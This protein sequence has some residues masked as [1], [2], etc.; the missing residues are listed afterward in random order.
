[1]NRLARKNYQCTNNQSVNNSDVGKPTWDKDKIKQT[2]NNCPWRRFAEAENYTL[3]KQIFSNARRSERLPVPRFCLL[4]AIVTHLNH[5]CFCHETVI[6]C[7]KN[8]IFL[9]TKYN[10]RFKQP[11][12]HIMN[13]WFILFEM[14]FAILQQIY[15][16]IVRKGSAWV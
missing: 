2:K 9:F 11:S 8:G 15:K 12:V 4:S 7:S 5:H 14:F 10:Q 16:P 1:M 3:K 6:F 13:R